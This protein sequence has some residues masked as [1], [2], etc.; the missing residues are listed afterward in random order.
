[1]PPLVLVCIDH[2]ASILPALGQRVA[3]RREHS[4]RPSGGDRHAGSRNREADSASRESA[5]SAARPA[6]RCSRTCWHRI[7][8][9]VVQ[10]VVGGDHTI[11][12]GEVEAA[13]VA[14]TAPLLYYRGGYSQ[15]DR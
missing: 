15:L 5:S 4:G 9:R 3:F 1:M 14:R 8:C 7:E 6:P 10:S 12:M 11:F 2:D 13:N